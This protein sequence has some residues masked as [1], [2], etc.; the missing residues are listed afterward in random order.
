MNTRNSKLLIKTFDGSLLKLNIKPKCMNS[1][2]AFDIQY[3]DYDGDNALI[4]AKIIFKEVVSIDFEI[5]FFDNC[6]GSELCGFYEI[7]DN[8]KKK[9][10]I[11]KIFQARREGHLYHGD[12]DYDEN[13]END[14]LNWREPIDKI[15]GNIGKYNLYQQ[16]TDGGIY[17]ILA[18]GYDIIKT[19][20][21]D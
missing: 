19:Q 17:Y 14:R 8:E 11:E 7:F 12:Y 20:L 3:Y 9:E 16:Q 4:Q 13:D 6:I 5:N 18:S 2:V 21:G 10:M 15:V 1:I